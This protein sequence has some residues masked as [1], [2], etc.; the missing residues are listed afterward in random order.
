VT[1]K[2]S[3]VLVLLVLMICLVCGDLQARTDD[4]E[5]TTILFIG[6]SYFNRNDLPGLFQ[7]LADSLGFAVFIDQRIP[8][9]L[10]L[11]D[12]ARSSETEV[13]IRE[14]QWDYVILQGVGRLMA[15]PEAFLDHP[16]YPSLVRL[17]DIIVDNCA[18]TRIVFC[19][20]W[21]Y[22]D[23]M[24]WY[25]D[26]T[27]TF[28]DMQAHIYENTVQYSED[29]GFAIAPVGWAW[30]TVLEELRYPLHYLHVH[31]WNHPSLRGSYLSACTIF[32]SVYL[33]SSV[34][35]DFP[36]GLPV[37]DVMYFQEVASSTVLEDLDLWNLT[38]DVGIQPDPTPDG[39][40]TEPAMPLGFRLE[41][42]HPNPF[43]PHTRISFSVGQTECIRVSILDLQGR[44]VRTLANR[45]FERGTYSV[46]WLGRD[47]AGHAVPSGA[48]LV[49]L[50]TGNR[51]ESRK[52]MLVR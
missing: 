34:G 46:D 18:S 11:W 50:Q 1:L 20:P 2:P 52:I 43:N 31:D 15:Y 41:R 22:E 14:R 8:G 44:T 4:R 37:D 19:M 13:K 17:R 38:E 25:A 51:V 27:D 7:G 30:R 33:E 10:Y 29:I 21:A 47:E 35:V 42:I 16:V 48:Y 5:P 45:R 28:D 36:A 3:G 9:G 32:T 23:G 39:G 40:T 12:H 24:T 26:W 6:S 49:F